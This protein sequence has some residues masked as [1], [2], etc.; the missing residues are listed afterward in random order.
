MTE[1]DAVLFD[2]DGV[3]V[4]TAN[5]WRTLEAEEILPAAG[6]GID[7]E[8]VRALSVEDSYERL[9]LMASV[10]LHVDRQG[11]LDLYNGYAEEVYRE[12]AALM[13]GYEAFVGRLDDRGLGIGLVSAS[14]REWVEMVLDRF[15][16]WDAYDVILSATDVDGPS[17]P[18]PTPYLMAADSLGVDPERCIV[19]ED[20]VHGIESATAAGAY[21]IALRGAGNETTD[22]STADAIADDAA[23]LRERVFELLGGVDEGRTVQGTQST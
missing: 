15:D 16:L 22:L 7:I 10:T 2:M 3:T 23:D 13:D 8:D 6:D 14:C 5:A 4:S 19:V 9:D 17:K 1:Y 20:S 18:D 21:C 12:R 11:F